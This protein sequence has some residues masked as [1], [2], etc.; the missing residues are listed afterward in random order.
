MKNVFLIETVR[1][2]SKKLSVKFKFK[3]KIQKELQWLTKSIFSCINSVSVVHSIT[4]S[5]VIAYRRQGGQKSLI[6]NKSFYWEIK[7]II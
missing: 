4:T 5:V 2:I 6:K 7:Y 1:H 3:R